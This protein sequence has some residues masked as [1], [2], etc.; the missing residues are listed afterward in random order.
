MVGHYA[1]CFGENQAGCG[2]VPREQ[3]EFKVQIAAAL[4]QISQLQRAG[5]EAAEI[6]A[7]R[8][9]FRYDVDAGLRIF[10]LVQAERR[11]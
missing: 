10:L 8:V 3:A 7:L 6:R 2:K 9:G 11:T 5:A 1:A 4:G